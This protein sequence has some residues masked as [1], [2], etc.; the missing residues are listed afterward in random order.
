MQYLGLTLDP[1]QEDAVHAL[2]NNRSVVVSAPTGSGKT[3]IANYLIDVSLK[4]NK[5][6]IYTAPIKALS[7]QKFKEFKKLY[8]I[9]KVGLMTGDTVIDSQAPVLIMTTEIYRNMVLVKDRQIDDVAAVIF[10][11]VHYINDIE[12]GYVWE[13][14]LIFSPSHVRFLCLS[15]TIPNAKELAEWISSIKGHPVDTI[16]HEKRVVPLEHKF[17]DI[18]LG[19]TS[20]QEIEKLKRLPHANFSFERGRKKK[21]R[22]PAPSH[23]DLIREL[24]DNVPC[25]YFIFSREGTE[26]KAYEL[27]KKA[28][29]PYSQ[30]IAR[31]VTE[32]LSQAPPEINRIESAR[33]LR[34]ILPRQIAFHHAGLLPVLKNIV[35]DLF[36]KGLIK[37]LFAT[38]TFAVGINMPAKTVCFDSLRKFDGINH[39]YLNT[40]EY[41]QMAGRAGRRGIDTHGL[42]V[43]MVYR[44]M[45]DF[46]KIRQITAKDSD[47]IYSQFRLGVNTLLNMINLHSPEENEIILRQSFM[48]YQFKVRGRKLDMHT[49]FMNLAKRLE[50]MGYLGSGRLTE[51]GMFASKIYSE[52][53]LTTELFGTGIIQQFDELQIM[54]LLALIVYEPRVKD[55]FFAPLNY[56]KILGI[57]HAVRDNPELRKDRK[58]DYLP[59]LASLVEPCFDRKTFFDLIELSS[60]SE[61]DLIR[62]FGQ[63]L[64]RIQQIRRASTN[65]SLNAV[66]ANLSDK[67]RLFLDE[68][69]VL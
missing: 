48:A 1:F 32:E 65:H 27:F 4:E 67:I 43:S 23:V 45:A 28:P 31:I 54:V 52:E 36:A 42:V 25:L 30:E 5:K 63:M 34:E 18:D 35:E 60:L 19:I 61:G 68:V 66:L 14:S 22:I 56:P 13:E 49:R 59:A 15:A 64:D 33:V 46:E 26:D 24:G 3:L 38:E 8:G 69:N 7:N 9:G 17:F 10:D 62:L 21:L 40:K 2:E 37:V 6:V 16:I 47:P 57:R 20:I 50:K 41:F 44:Q 29:F 58:F 53:I 11:E 39:R 55:R 12:R 51:K